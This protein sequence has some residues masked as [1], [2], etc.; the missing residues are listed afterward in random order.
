[1][2]KLDIARHVAEALDIKDQD[3]MRIV[4]EIINAIRETVVENGRLEIRNFGIFQIK[5]R[6]PKIGRNPKTKVEYPIPQRSV[7]TFK[8]GKEI[9]TV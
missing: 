3:A 9:K 1:M 5:Q 6:K 4:N 2:I 7:V 8:S